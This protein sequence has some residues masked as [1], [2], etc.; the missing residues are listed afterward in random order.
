MK[1]II[2]VVPFIMVWRRNIEVENIKAEKY[3]SREISKQ[4]NIKAEK[5][6]SREISKQRNIKAEKY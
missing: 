2:F 6:Q 4:R 1:I 3:Q 5:Y